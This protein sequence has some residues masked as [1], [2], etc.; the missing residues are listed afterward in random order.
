MCVCVCTCIRTY[1]SIAGDL[2]VCTSHRGLQGVTVQ[3]PVSPESVWKVSLINSGKFHKQ[4]N[5]YVH[6]TIARLHCKDCIK[7]SM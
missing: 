5:N 4:Y 3:V 6:Y 7:C 2:I 1:L